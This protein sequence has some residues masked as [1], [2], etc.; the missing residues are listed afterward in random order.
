MERLESR[1]KSL[2]PPLV[3]LHNSARENNQTAIL[4]L[5]S[6]FSKQAEK[7]LTG[8]IAAAHQ[9]AA[10]AVYT[11]QK[12]VRSGNRPASSDNGFAVENPETQLEQAKALRNQI[13]LHLPREME[14]GQRNNAAL[15]KP[16][17]A[18]YAMQRFEPT[19]VQSFN[20]GNQPMLL[21]LRD[22]YI[23]DTA[24][25]RLYENTAYF[26]YTQTPGGVVLHPGRLT[27][28]MAR[29]RDV[30]RNLTD[31][32]KQPNEQLIG[33]QILRAIGEIH[34]GVKILGAQQQILIQA[35]RKRDTGTITRFATDA[36]KIHFKQARAWANT[37]PA[38]EQARHRD[39]LQFWAIQTKNG[40]L[41][42]GEV[43]IAKISIDQMTL[44]DWIPVKLKGENKK[45][46]FAKKPVNIPWSEVTHI[47]RPIGWLNRII[48]TILAKGNQP[49]GFDK[50]ASG[51][52]VRG[53]LAR[54]RN[55]GTETVHTS[56]RLNL[57]ISREF[58]AAYLMDRDVFN[59]NLVQLLLLGAADEDH[60]EL[61]YF[62]EQGR[63]YRFVR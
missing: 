22:R 16:R 11:L 46:A 32:S 31:T 26:Q 1:V 55:T 60:F 47:Y 53:R 33:N 9:W 48:T 14:E 13:A 39:G 19:P 50:L 34:P 49:N 41:I 57:V 44:L 7:G 61:I 58:G 54:S 51:A 21:G 35:I 30:I 18:E 36:A 6:L 43:D 20:P 56:S 8:D 24:D 15:F 2:P 5:K 45:Q 40:R 10:R 4:Q 29:V 17:G 25:L 62:N 38:A 42:A 27:Q 52:I 28:G 59:S 23:V 63:L 3:Q 12:R 37:L